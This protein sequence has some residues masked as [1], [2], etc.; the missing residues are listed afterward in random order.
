MSVKQIPSIIILM[1]TFSSS[2]SQIFDHKSINKKLLSDSTQI[3]EQVYRILKNKEFVYNKP[4][5]FDFL[6]KAPSDLKTHANSYIQKKNLPMLGAIIATTIMFVAV[7]QQFIE[8]ARDLG[9][10]LGISSHDYQLNISPSSDLALYLPTDIGTSMYF[11]GDGL[12]HLTINAAFLT[13]GLI[14]KNNR[15]LQTASQISEGLIIVGVCGQILKHITGRESPNKA[16]APGGVWRVFPNQIETIKDVP[17]YDA[18]P[19]GHL[20]TAMMTVTVIAENYP[21]YK[22]IRPIGYTLMTLLSYQMLNNGVHWMSDYP[23]ALFIGYDIAKIV[24]NNGR[25]VRDQQSLSKKSGIRNWFS[26]VD[27]SPAIVRNDGIGLRLRYM[28]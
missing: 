7:D 23:L 16:T 13:Y 18:F 15:A 4:K 27:F 19:S 11:I 2:Y 6:K 25:K 9:R 12:T 10:D 17:K 20:A 8:S 14:A 21:E 28:F 3:E 22:F 5:M 1:W 26:S 24:V